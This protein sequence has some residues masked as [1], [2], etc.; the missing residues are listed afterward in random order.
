MVATIAF[1]FQLIDICIDNLHL[2]DRDRHIMQSHL[3]PGYYLKQA[4]GKER[5][6]CRK[7]ELLEKANEL[8]SITDSLDDP[9]DKCSDRKIEEMEKA[10]KNCAQLFQRSSSCVEGRNAQLALRHQGI[11]RLGESQ[12]K[13]LTIVHN[14]YITRRDGTTAAERFYETKPNDL[15]NFV[16]NHMDYPMRPRSRLKLVT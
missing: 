10:A 3:I 2:S 9:H 4:A 5:D 12:L 1:F 16:L 8:L 15:F 11:H 14:Y 13:A 7:A 6:V